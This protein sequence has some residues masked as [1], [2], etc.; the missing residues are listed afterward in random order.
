[1]HAI[2]VSRI[3]YIRYAQRH[4]IGMPNNLS[5]GTMKTKGLN[6]MAKIDYD[7]GL[8]DMHRSFVNSYID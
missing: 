4:N 2:R 6:M 3:T 8:R 7:N 1:M 5:L